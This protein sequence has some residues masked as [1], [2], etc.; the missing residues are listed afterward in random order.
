MDILIR[1]KRRKILNTFFICFCDEIGITAPF[2]LRAAKYQFP[3]PT[4]IMMTKQK[5]AKRISFLTCVCDRRFFIWIIFL[6][7]KQICYIVANFISA[8][9]CRQDI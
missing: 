9:S 8:F 1:Q 6:D 2:T 4:S 3:K 5:I 7:A